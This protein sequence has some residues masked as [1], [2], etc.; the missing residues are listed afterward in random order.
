ME[1][2][3][4]KQCIEI[5]KIHHKKGEN[6]AEMVRKTRTFVGHREAACR[7]AIQ[8]SVKKFGTS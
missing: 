2:D 6:L 8:K 7:A 5:I 3:T 4:P 1:R